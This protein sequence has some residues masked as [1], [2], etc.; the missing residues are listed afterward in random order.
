MYSFTDDAFRKCK[1]GRPE[2]CKRRFYSIRPPT[3]NDRR[4]DPWNTTNAF[5]PDR[6]DT[7]SLDSFRCNLKLMHVTWRSASVTRT[8]EKFKISRGLN[9]N[10]NGGV[11]NA[12]PRNGDNTRIPFP[13]HA[14]P[15]EAAPLVQPCVSTILFPLSLSSF[16]SKNRTPSRRIAR[17]S[18]Y[19]RTDGSQAGR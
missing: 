2:G 6:P 5:Y 9:T 12:P 11:H 19:R 13:G 15:T 7:R 10:L 16:L 18:K 17:C 8:G 4:R 1:S 3:V 14:D